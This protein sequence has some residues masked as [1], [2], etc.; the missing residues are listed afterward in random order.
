M[1]A[2]KFL[3]GTALG[4][5]LM[6][7]SAIAQ[8]SGATPPVQTAAATES[9]ETGL[10]E[11]T[12]T[13]QRRGENIQRVPIAVSAISA[14]QLAATGMAST[15]DIKLAVAS[16]DVPI[17]NGYALPFI[18]GIGTKAVGP[19]TESSVSTYV[20]NVYIGSAV[21]ALLSFNNIARIE[22]L[23]GPQGT[24]FGR[25][26]T[27]GLIS[28]ITRDPGNQLE[29]DAR[30]S[31]G[32]YETVHGDLYVG[33]PIAGDVKAD[34]A[35]YV[36]HQGEGYG[37]NFFTG[38]DIG[39]VFYDYGLRT[40][41]LVESGPLTLRLTADYGAAKTSTF[42]QRV[43]FG[44]IAPPPYGVGGN[45][46]GGPW[47]T[48]LSLSP[49]LE[50]RGGG[51]SAKIDYEISSAVSLTSITAWRKTRYH[52]HFDGDVTR[53]NATEVDAIQTDRQFSQ[54]LQLLSGPGSPFTWVLG[55]YL[56]DAH[57]EYD[58]ALRILNGPA[59][60]GPFTGVRNSYTYAQQDVFSIAPY[61]QATIEVLPGTKLSL[62]ARFT[63]ERRKHHGEGTNFGPAGAQVGPTAT[64][65]QKLDANKLT[66]RIALD[67]QFGSDVLGYASYNRGFKSGGGNLTSVTAPFYRPEQLDAYEVGLKSTLFDRRVRLNGAA[68]YYDYKD[69]QVVSQS[70]GIISIYN[71]AAARTYGFEVELDAQV[72]DALR[73]NAGYTYLDAKFTDFPNAVINV[74]N[75]S[76]GVRQIFGSAK[77]NSLPNA[78]KN[79]VTFGAS[80]SVPIGTN[81]LTFNGNIYHNSGFIAE[82]DGFRRQQ[83]YEL[84]NASVDFTF[85]DRYSISIWGKNLSNTAV[86]LFPSVNGLGGG[87]GVPRSSYAPPRTYGATIGVKL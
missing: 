64:I 5:I 2:R 29:L 25:N 56:Y 4:L 42:V 55:A 26:A 14:D 60:A 54:E 80:Y 71:G 79:V 1:P 16:A 3:Q 41:W 18:R 47:D 67:H 43:A 39:R 32:N 53:T 17:L 40:K 59:S 31:Y 11:I 84:Y 51:V 9:A 19:A 61:A 81:Q 77:G 63:Y 8:T 24:L 48:D 13:A 23:K 58:P 6:P 30:A 66:W 34:F 46:G 78:P 69:I 10:A 50:T 22:V 37:T 70:A 7:V 73:V 62:G 35:A 72:T 74:V 49:V 82:P 27:G 12:V 57:G 75:P 38:K 68:F 65:D 44:F 45:Y 36:N 15:G 20:D 33:G 21:G 83:A 76:G 85:G 52:N 86:D 28:I 87:L